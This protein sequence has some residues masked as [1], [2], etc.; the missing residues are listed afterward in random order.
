[1]R[2]EEAC[3]EIFQRIFHSESA[4]HVFRAVIGQ[5]EPAESTRLRQHVFDQWIEAQ[6]FDSLKLFHQLGTNAIEYKPG[7]AALSLRTLAQ[8][9]FMRRKGTG[10]GMH[11]RPVKSSYAMITLAN[12]DSYVI[13]RR[14]LEHLLI[15][16]EQGCE[17]ARKDLRETANLVRNIGQEIMRTSV[18]ALGTTAYLASIE[19]S[20]LKKNPI[21][22][23]PPIMNRFDYHIHPRIVEDA[24]EIARGSINIHPKVRPERSLV[25]WNPLV[26][27]AKNAKPNFDRLLR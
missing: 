18:R 22:N 25:D 1:M 9:I 8:L 26:A 19:Y 3:E 6:L 21:K 20:G 16:Y 14:L 11:T 27:H 2:A 23:P 24:A 10:L 13:F 5:L 4:E 15:R 7:E 17:Y 12:D